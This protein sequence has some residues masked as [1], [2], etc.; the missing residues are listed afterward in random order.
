V[1]VITRE[2]GLSEL[3]LGS[4][5]GSQRNKNLKKGARKNSG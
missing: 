3:G 5:R 2:V 1:I 4:I